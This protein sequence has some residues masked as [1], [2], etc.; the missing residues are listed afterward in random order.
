[1]ES[2]NI[3]DKN[4]DFRADDMEKKLMLLFIFEKMEF[5]LTDNSLAEIIGF[6]PNWMN[7]MDYKEALYLLMESRFIHRTSH[8]SDCLFYITDMGRRCLAH[9]YTKIPAS[10]REEITSYAKSN[11][12]NFKRSQEYTTDYFAN[13]DGTHT[14]LL[15]IR[16]NAAANLLEIRMKVPTRA[17]AKN[18]TNKWR[19]KA[20]SVY[21]AIF[22]TLIEE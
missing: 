12:S 6:N 10:I 19:E 18:A 3:L 5:P 16:E 9:F 17:I 11:R 22:N 2:P 20:P 1:M 4:T 8:G 21:E 7:Y 13:S 15:R 14:I